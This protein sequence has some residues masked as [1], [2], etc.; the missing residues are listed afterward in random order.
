MSLIPHASCLIPHPPPSQVLAV[1]GQVALN[2][3][4][5]AA[6][7]SG[8]IEEARGTKGSLAMKA[9]LAKAKTT[10]LELTLPL[11]TKRKMA[12]HLDK[13][14]RTRRGVTWRGAAWRGVL[15]GVLSVTY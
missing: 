5:N 10:L 3:F 13:L 9:A 4:E 7:V 8:L 14:V 11:S 2:A 6:V 12:A 15:P 1:T